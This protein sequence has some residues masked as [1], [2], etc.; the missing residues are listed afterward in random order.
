[1]DNLLRKMSRFFLSF[2][3]ANSFREIPSGAFRLM[4]TKNNFSIFLSHGILWS[5][6]DPRITTAHLKCQ[7]GKPELLKVWGL[8]WNPRVG[9]K[10]I[11][12]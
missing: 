10:I 1:M 12:S 5:L 2:K 7:L 4:V 8:T 11:L 3:V 9:V 6:T